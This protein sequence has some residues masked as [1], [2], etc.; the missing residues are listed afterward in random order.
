MRHIS[1]HFTGFAQIIVESH[2]TFWDFSCIFASMFCKYLF[3][4]P[5][6]LHTIS[7]AAH[8]QERQRTITES[9]IKALIAWGS[10]RDLIVVALYS[11]FSLMTYI[12]LTGRLVNYD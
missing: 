8:S 1:E 2:Y 6:S 11:K 3:Y 10:A 9:S 12:I 4:R 7:E 5:C